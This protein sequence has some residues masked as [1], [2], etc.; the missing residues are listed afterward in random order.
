VIIDELTPLG[1][2]ALQELSAKVQYYSNHLL[3]TTRTYDI[4]CAVFSH[5][6][7]EPIPLPVIRPA[8]LWTGK[9]NLIVE[10]KGNLAVGSRYFNNTALQDSYLCFV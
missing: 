2:E 10:I 5:E 8:L 7:L 4:Y 1:N 9:S 6:V 3:Y